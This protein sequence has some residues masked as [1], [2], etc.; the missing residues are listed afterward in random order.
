MSG[1]WS[2]KGDTSLGDRIL[3]VDATDDINSGAQ[4]PPCASGEGVL[5][6]A[7]GSRFTGKLF[8]APTWGEGELFYT[9]GMPGYQETLTDP[10]IAGQV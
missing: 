3:L 6:L 9:T 5:L 10:S 8:G 1:E 7:D 2:Q 4:I